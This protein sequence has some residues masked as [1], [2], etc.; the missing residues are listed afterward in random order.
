MKLSLTIIGDFMPSFLVVRF[1]DGDR[2]VPSHYEERFDPFHGRELLEI[3]DEMDGI[4]FHKMFHGWVAVE[5]N[6]ERFTEETLSRSCPDE[7]SVDN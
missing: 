4:V 3:P 2:E 5:V 7:F 1:P 6:D